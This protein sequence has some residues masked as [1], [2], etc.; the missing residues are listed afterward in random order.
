MPVV[1]LPVLI[2]LYPKNTQVFTITGLQDVVTGS[3]LD[4]AA[5]TATLVDQRGNP[6]PVI[7]EITMTYVT[8]SN[9][10]YQGTAPFTFDAPLGDGYT[11]EVTALQAGVQSFYSFPVKVLLRS[12]Q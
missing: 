6:D 3:Y 1:N 11:L 9:G 12:E 7:N 5:V 10:N 2:L 8:A 4:A